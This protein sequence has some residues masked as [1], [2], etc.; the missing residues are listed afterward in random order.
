M[1]AVKLHSVRTVSIIE[2]SAIHDHHTLTIHGVHSTRHMLVSVE[3]GLVLR[4]HPASC[5]DFTVFLIDFQSAIHS[6]RERSS[7]QGSCSP[8]K[9][10]VRTQ[11]Q[12]Y[13]VSHGH[14]PADHTP[15]LSL[16][17]SGPWWRL[18][19]WISLGTRPFTVSR[20]LSPVTDFSG[21][22]AEPQW[23]LL[24]FP[25]QEPPQTQLHFIQTSWL[26]RTGCWDLSKE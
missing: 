22:L 15:G 12:G 11:C 9:G 1:N 6:R 24:S 3:Q 21:A 19:I 16:L 4:L 13:T 7:I 25:K 26:W 20:K 2:M 14:R 23:V 17:D 8:L 5:P 10:T 18:G